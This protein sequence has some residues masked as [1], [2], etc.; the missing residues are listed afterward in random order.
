MPNLVELFRTDFAQIG[1]TNRSCMCVVPSVPLNQRGKTTDRIVVGSQNGCVICVVRRQNDTQI[2][3]KTL[4]GPAI[5]G[6]RLGGSIGTLAN[7]VFVSSDTNVR[8]L[9][10]KGKQFF[11]FDT[12]MAEPIKSMFIYGVD[13][14]LTGTKSFNHYHDC[15][16]TNYYLS[17]EEINDVV[18]LIDKSGGAWAD[19]PFTSVLACRDST[20]KVLEG[21]QLVYELQ[22]SDVPTIVHLFME[23]G[24]FSSQKVFY[25]TRGGNIGLVDL[26]SGGGSIVWQLTT[27]TASAITTVTFYPFISSERRDLIIGKD[28]GVVEVYTIDEEDS[29]TLASVYSS[30][31]T[32]TGLMC[33]RIS[34]EG[35][36]E[37]II[38][39]YTGWL[40][41]LST[42]QLTQEKT[43]SSS[44]MNVKVKVDQLRSE[45]HDLE[46]KVMEERAKYSEITQKDGTSAYFP[47]F[48]VHDSF[49]FNA[50]FG[51]YSMVI[52]LVL[53]ID[54]IIVQSSLMV[55]L[56]EVEKNASVVCMLPQSE[57]NPWPLLASYRC[58]AKT[59]RIELRVK[60]EEGLFGKIVVYV[61]PNIHPKAAQVRIF[62][63]KPLSAHVRVHQIDN[64][65]PMNVLSISGNFT[66]AEA[67]AWLVMLIPEIPLKAPPTDSV[68]LNLQN[69]VNGGT[70]L[71]AVYSRGSVVFRSDSISTIAIIR[72]RISAETTK[73]QIRVQIQCDLNE[74]S[75]SHCLRL[76]HPQLTRL[77]E[78]EKC[79]MLATALRELEVS[80]SDISFLSD[81][82]KAILKSHDEVYAEAEK[83]PIETSNIFSIYQNLLVDRARLNGKNVKNHIGPLHELLRNNYSLDSC[84]AFFKSVSEDNNI[85]RL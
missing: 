3:Y 79:K 38:C 32:I 5:T 40:F 55:K 54:Y 45:V 84:I 16:D 21:S 25:G 66:L 63:V 1:T 2:I 47:A 69:C 62:E 53:P 31:E 52:E 48:Q 77:L 11:S 12:N 4:P 28:D 18:C 33:G 59:S 34:D 74:D 41:S 19:R 58:Q 10:K 56:I 72:D 50:T 36:D 67:H 7:K 26:P 71:Q 13:L 24:G 85:K 68:T 20:L 9:G 35:K 22:L 80:C 43:P 82:N 73:S 44:T 14:V 78:T 8:G 29:A 75:V 27:T 83:N 39:T 15:S 49:E 81:D 30:D 6:L 42:T 23:D 61:C 57:H 65:R 64:G 17:S 60:V 37:I 46:M 76:L 70:Q 51:A